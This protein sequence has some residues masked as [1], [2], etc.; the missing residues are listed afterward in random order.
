[1]KLHFLI[2]AV[3]LGMAIHVHAQEKPVPPATKPAVGLDGSVAAAGGKPV[4][5]AYLDLENRME[6]LILKAGPLTEVVAQ[7]ERCFKDDPKK[8]D[9]DLPNLVYAKN[10]LDAVVPGDLTLRRVTPVQALALVAAAADCS[11]RPIFAPDEK[12]GQK[13]MIIGYRIEPQAASGSGKTSDGRSLN[14]PGSPSGSAGASSGSSQSR[15]NLQVVD[16][17]APGGTLPGIARTR[18][19]KNS[20]G[21][22]AGMPVDN[23]QPFVRVY[24]IG[25]I[26]NGTDAEVGK[27]MKDLEEV[28][29]QTLIQAGLHEAN[30]NHNFHV[31]T[32]TFMAKATAAQHEII[33]QVIKAINENEARPAAPAKP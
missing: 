1:M 31:R 18:V 4:V 3:V 24:A 28:L 23:N 20:F 19:P 16:P 12:A 17:N 22:P 6:T 13:V 21:E 9:A 11:F 10:S 5:G 33:E 32:G 8:P 27:K 29:A 2:S 14:T 30:P 26:K 7:V 15:P 25:F